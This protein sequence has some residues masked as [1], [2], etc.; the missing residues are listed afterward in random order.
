MQ[1]LIRDDNILLDLHRSCFCFD[2]A[3]PQ[4]TYV[5]G[6]ILT[7]LQPTDYNIG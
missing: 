4:G 2:I 3:L 1:I 7:I 6:N 5:P